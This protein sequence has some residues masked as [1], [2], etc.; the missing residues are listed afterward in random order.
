MAQARR[1]PAAAQATNVP[2]FKLSHTEDR[3][4]VGLIKYVEM[5]ETVAKFELSQVHQS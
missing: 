4:E 5:D 3:T 2:K 1:G